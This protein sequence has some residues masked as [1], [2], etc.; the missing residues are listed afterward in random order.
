MKQCSSRV[1]G[2]TSGSNVAM[3]SFSVLAA[4]LFAA[5]AQAE[6]YTLDNDQ[7]PKNNVGSDDSPLQWG[8]DANWNPAG[9]PGSED[10]IQWAPT[11][12]W[13]A[14]HAYLSLDKDYSVGKIAGYHR[15]LH[16]Y[17]AS[18]AE[19]EIV[20]LTACTQ[21]GEG[22]PQ[23]YVLN[24]GTKFVVSESVMLNGSQ[25]DDVGSHFSLSGNSEVDV[26]GS[27][28]S[29]HIVWNVPAGATLRF[30]PK[31]YSNTSSSI[32]DIFNLTGGDVYFPNGIVATGGNSGNANQIN[33]SAGTVTFGGDFTSAVTAWTYTWS[34][35]TLAATDNVTFSSNVALTIP[36]SAAVTLDVAE[37]KS[38]SAQNIAADSTATITKTGAG[39]FALSSMNAAVT[40]K[41]GGI[42]FASAGPNDLSN[43][44][45]ES[46]TK[47]VLNTLGATLNGCN[48]TLTDN[49][50]FVADL[51]SAKAG[52]LVLVSDSAD[53]LAKAKNDLSAPAGLALTISGTMLVVEAQSDYNFTTTGSILDAQCWGG[54]VP[55]TGAE[56]AISGEGVVATLPAE[57]QFPAWQSIEVKNG[58]KLRIEANTTLP[59]IILSLDSTLEIATGVTVTLSDEA[60]LVC[61][62]SDSHLPILSVATDATLVVPGGMKFKN[63]DFRLYGTIAKPSIDALSPVF[64]YAENGETSYIAMTVD[65]GTFDFHSNQNR[66]CGS[67]SIVCPAA[68][69]RVVPVGTIVLKN[70]TRNVTGWDDFGNWEF[71]VNNPVDQPFDVLID[72]TVLDCSAYFY[73]SGAAHLSL[74][75]NSK[76]QRNHSCLGHYFSMAIQNSATVSVASGSY[77]DF[78]T[79][80]GSFGIDSQIAV[81]AVTVG[82][83]GTYNVAYNSSGW[84]NG[85][86]VAN[87][88]VLGVGKLYK[89]T[90]AETPRERTDLLLG[91]ASAR[92][93]GDLDIASVDFDSGNFEWERNVKVAANVP[94]TGAGNVTIKNGV[95]ASP[96]TVTIQNGNNTATGS[97]SVAPGEGEGATTLYF[98]SGANWAGK[99][100]AGNIALTNLEDAEAPVTVT[101][102]ELD[103][104]GENFPL[105]VWKTDG[106]I[107]KNDTLNVDTYTSNGGKLE[108]VLVGGGD[109]ALGDKIVVGKIKKGGTL[110]ALKGTWLVAIEDIDG[111]EEYQL[112]TLT[113]GRGLTVILR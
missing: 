15:Y 96:F 49:A 103:L 68:G 66:N 5:S 91:F 92:L 94:F 71:G 41:E 54:D 72:G 51:S 107:A 30:A 37:G 59:H 101:F 1:L 21:L 56:V 78:T 85:A 57:A 17:K 23:Y 61:N 36:A 84:G 13:D 12:T 104:N 3:K 2:V 32:G 87:G 83:G 64:G 29:R 48:A 86:F 20:T 90:A 75:N 43:F 31:V 28:E 62:A 93:D 38:F 19:A 89:K 95:P 112:L 35:G 63:V 22:Q 53:L 47:V 81:D 26:F 52:T 58:A 44:T 99:V 113:R 110:P 111:D 7:E 45:F 76:I 27:I 55:P 24:A 9:V 39:V 67:V 102:G 14:R 88:G 105:R 60:N 98:A 106:A 18:N 109:F 42:G 79:G 16:L 40:V 77:I 73:A 70:A 33:H 69:G 82:D 8:I 80:D 100:V 46:G 25:W 11:A 10:T 74:V 108:P 6:T 50:V 34:G 4:L 65:G 97:I